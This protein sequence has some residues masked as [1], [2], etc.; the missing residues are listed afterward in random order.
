MEAN[1]KRKGFL[2]W[3]PATTLY[4]SAKP[5][6]STMQYSSSKVKPSPTAPSP[7]TASVGFIINYEY[8]TQTPKQKVAS[9]PTRERYLESIY[10]VVGEEGVDKEA[11]SYISIVQERFKLEG[12]N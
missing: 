1:R 8:V 6:S 5:V 12:V 10:G 4:R 2:K 7:T 9:F 3:K 11:A